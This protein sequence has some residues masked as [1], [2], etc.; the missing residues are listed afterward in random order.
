MKKL[1]LALFISLPLHAKTTAGCSPEFDSLI[2]KYNLDPD[3][4]EIAQ[5]EKDGKIL[6]DELFQ[7]RMKWHKQ[8]PLLPNDCKVKLKQ[9]FLKMREREDY[10]G[11]HFY[12]APQISANAIDYKKIPLPIYS[13]ESYAPYH[14]ADS[15]KKFAFQSGDILIT[16]G[17][18]F[19]SSTISEVVAQRALFSHMV[20]IHVDEKTNV[21]STM[22]SYIGYGVKIFS[23]EEALRN[24]NARILV[25]RSKDTALAKQAAD[26]MFERIEKKES[27]GERI[28]YDYV[29][30]FNDN[31]KL[32]CEEIAYDAFK[33]VTSGKMI[34]P[35]NLSQVDLKDQEFL[36]Q[37]GIKAGP[38]M[39]P[40]DL[41]IDSRFEIV[42]DWTD[43]RVIRDSI[44]K[45]AVMGEVFHWMN[46]HQY[47][48]HSSM[49]S[50]AA[51]MIWS[52]RYI[53]GLWNL[54]ASVSG[55]P[56]DFQKDV[57]GVAIS[58]LEKIKGTAGPIL[59]FITTA[60]E[61]FH[62]E[63]NRWMTPVELRKNIDSYLQKNPKDVIN[64][65][66]K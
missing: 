64:H 34:I 49:R 18:S 54:L 55:I 42:L 17:V 47:K 1:V 40:I 39:M 60:D 5:F 61:E 22:E 27:A 25:L 24:E 12:K 53:P 63:N 58:T 15:Q 13:P 2:K 46:D 11:A 31:S 30:N 16:K 38:L 9:V 51:R 48:L 8:L 23:I 57:P 21:V 41:E 7:E 26:Y 62:R 28:P 19:T 4:A 6:L 35:E 3:K 45:D 43:Y 66:Y 14:L 50:I 20:F 37:I 59:T 52:T 32:S 65:F 56:A 44:R 10:I 33:T 36:E 29:L